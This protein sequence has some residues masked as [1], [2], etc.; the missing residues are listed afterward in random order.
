MESASIR[1]PSEVTGRDCDREQAFLRYRRAVVSGWPEKD[2][3]TVI[4]AAI[5]SRIKHLEELCHL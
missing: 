2:A 4:L 5:D 1:Y 3:K